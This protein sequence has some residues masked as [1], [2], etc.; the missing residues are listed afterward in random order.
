MAYA[1]GNVYQNREIVMIFGIQRASIVK[2]L[3][4]F[5]LDAILVVILA[6]GCMLAVSAITG[7]DAKVNELD[8]YYDKYAKEYGLE[9]LDISEEDYNKLTKEQKEVY[10]DAFSAL[11]KDSEAMGLYSVINTLMVTIPSIGIFIAFAVLEFTVPLILKNGQTI[12]KK[13]MALGVIRCDGVKMSTFMLFARTLLGKFTVE[14]MLPLMLFLLN[15]V[16]GSVGLLFGALLLI[17]ELVL[18]FTTQ[19]RTPIHDAFA[20]TVVID[21]PT[22]MIFESSEALLE[23]KTRV[24]AEAAE[25]AEYK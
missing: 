11:A 19:N 3:A 2:R 21:M 14:T 1:F 22:Q 20:Q 18:V 5:L 9:S 12:G 6:T 15:G 13:A 24:A 4:A 7:F 8:G 23:Y 25:K 16:F 17:F 10:D